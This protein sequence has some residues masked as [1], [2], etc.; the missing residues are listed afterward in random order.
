MGFLEYMYSYNFSFTPRRN[1]VLLQ[2]YTWIHRCSLLFVATRDRCIWTRG[3]AH[4]NKKANGCVQPRAYENGLV[5]VNEGASRGESG[6]T[7]M[8]ASQSEDG[9]TQPKANKTK[10][11]LTWM[12]GVAGAKV[13]THR[14]ESKQSESRCTQPKASKTKCWLTQMREVVGAKVGTHRWRSK[15]SMSGCTQPRPARPSAG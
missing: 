11:W 5:N 14:W 3:L 12:K 15:Q 2:S 8:G 1:V 6:H 9:C 7:Q 10:C 13:G 4:T